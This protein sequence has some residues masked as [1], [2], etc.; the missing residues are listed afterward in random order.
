MVGGSRG[1]LGLHFDDREGMCSLAFGSPSEFFFKMFYINLITVVCIVHVCTD[2][3]V[4]WHVRG[5][6]EDNTVEVTLS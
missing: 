6:V 2:K 4:P 3:H 5:G 1:G